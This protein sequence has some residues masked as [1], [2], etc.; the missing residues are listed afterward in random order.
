MVQREFTLVCYYGAKPAPLEALLRT[1]VELLASRWGGAF[2]PYALGQMHA[3]LI[4]LET[5]LVDGRQVNRWFWRHRG[6]RR[7][8][9][10]ER[11]TELI[12]ADPRLPIR[13][14]FGGF[15][16][17]AEYPFTSRGQRPYERMFQCQG[18]QVVLMGWPEASG[19]FP[20]TLA[21]LRREF[22]SA[23]LLH[24]YHADPA[25]DADNDLFLVLGQL[26]RS[27]LLA[28]DITAV[29]REAREFLARTPTWVDIDRD[30]LALVAYSD[31]RLPE[32]ESQSWNAEPALL[33]R[34]LG[35][36]G[37]PSP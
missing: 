34:V 30:A 28:T 6:E 23:N 37:R 3:T 21:E 18:A 8:L 31:P 27:R 13:I 35:A 22:E 33:R 2:E 32:A 14:R 4:G 10:A 12:E 11:L 20:A 26:D 25:R 36:G 9:D 19:T 1:L 5:E 17:R 15:H 29:E 16:P 24:K 7:L